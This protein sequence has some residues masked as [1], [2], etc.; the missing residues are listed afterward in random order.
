MEAI[1]ICDHDTCE[2]W[3]EEKKESERT[4]ILSLPALELSC[5]DENRM[6]HI[7]GYG[8][9]TKSGTRLSDTVE[10]IQNSRIEIL[11]Q[12]QKNL[13]AEGFKVDMEMVYKL[14]APHSPV[15]TNFANAIL[16]DPGNAGNPKLE[17]Y[18]PGG[19]K[20]DKPYIRFIRDYLV[21]GQKC[22]VPEYIVDI[23]SGIQMISEAG[24]IPVLAHPGEW[25]T[26]D[27][28]WKIDRMLECGLG[29]VE[30]YTPY[31][32]EEQTNYFEDLA[33]RYGLFATA[34]SDYHDLK[35]KPGHEMGMIEAADMEMFQTLQQMIREKK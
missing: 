19:E 8:I 34:G 4:G 6:V 33:K 31:H 12:I 14:A 9:D 7:L 28:E 22:Y 16:L 15:I 2:A 27:D 18:R 1:V 26:G 10:K 30:V 17:C 21:A 11:P 35:K 29:G 24:G 32:S 25:F 5:I 20:S 3:E 13:E 23:Y